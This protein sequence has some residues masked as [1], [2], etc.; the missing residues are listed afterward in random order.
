MTPF[1]ESQ[2]AFVLIV[3]LSCLIGVGGSQGSM[4]F[5]N[6]KYLMQILCRKP[7]N[8]IVGSLAMKSIGI[9]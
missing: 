1:H 9:V 8:E 7:T 2:E 6:L 3:K 5:Q 4:S